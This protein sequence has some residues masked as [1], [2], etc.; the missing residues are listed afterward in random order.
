MAAEA[1]ASPRRG[2]ASRRPRWLS[3]WFRTSR[4]SRSLLPAIRR[5]L[6]A[7]LSGA[8][9]P[10]ASSDLRVTGNKGSGSLVAVDQALLC[11]CKFLYTQAFLDECAVFIYDRTG[12]ST[13]VLSSAISRRLK[14]MRYTRKGGSTEA[15]QAFLPH[16][17]L[18]HQLFW[19]APR[20]LS[21]RGI[22][23]HQLLDTEEAGF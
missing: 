20:P 7:R 2:S 5:E 13:S 3:G 16:S 15:F 6:L 8:G 1:G 19:H 10:T 4:S 11:Y 23:R 9:G 17:I 12:R 22:Q 21:I 18:R 14:E